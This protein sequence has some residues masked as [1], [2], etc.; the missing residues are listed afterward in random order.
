MTC[1]LNPQ[2]QTPVK[3]ELNILNCSF[4]KMQGKVLFAEGL[5]FCT[6]LNVLLHWDAG[7][8][9]TN[10][11]WAPQNILS[12]FVYCKNHTSFENFKLKLCKC[13][14]NHALGTRKKFQLEIPTVNVISGIIYFHKIILESLWNIIETTPWSLS[15]MHEYAN[16]RCANLILSQVLCWRVMWSFQKTSTSVRRTSICWERCS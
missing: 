9:F 13:A 5:P 12:K 14:Q 15:L 11:L 2:Q 3:F 7:G 1:Q 8:C 16:F 4:N 6:G 10:V